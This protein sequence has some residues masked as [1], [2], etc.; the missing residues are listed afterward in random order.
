MV[1]IPIAV[2]KTF[3]HQ[4][5]DARVSIEVDKSFRHQVGDA[6]VSTCG[7]APQRDFVLF[8]HFR[9]KAGIP[10]GEPRMNTFKTPAF[11]ADQFHDEETRCK[12]K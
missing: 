8:W 1:K 11:R 4:L 5:G 7:N 2:D 12:T 9:G 10:F 3:R 6:R